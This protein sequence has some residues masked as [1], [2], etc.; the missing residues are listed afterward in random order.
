MRH[1]LAT[2]AVVAFAGAAQAQDAADLS[3]VPQ[4]GTMTVTYQE[5]VA[6]L[7]P[8]I[9]YDWQNWSMIKSLFDGLMGYEPGTTELRNELAE[10]HEV[11]E[12][13]MVHTFTLKDDIFFHN[14]REIMAEDVKY[15]LDR[16]T[17][18]E[19]Q[20]PGAGFF[21]MIEG[22]DAWNS[23]EGEGLSGVEVMDD[24][25]VQI[26]LSRPDATFGHV[27]ALNFASIVPA[28]GGGGVGPGLRPRPGRL[29]RIRTDGMDAGPAPRLRGV[30]PVPPR[31]GAE[32]RPGRLR[33]GAGPYR[34][35]SAGAA[36]AGGH[37]RRPDPAGAV[38]AG[39]ERPRAGRQC[40]RG[41]AVAH[42]L[43]D[44]ERQHGA[45]R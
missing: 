29:R 16:V 36:G 24:K 39:D 23:G 8:A 25:T 4:G 11:S 40:R 45:V 26:T 21:G 10:S 31:G 41:R 12:D 44:D 2:T 1:L 13:G 7:D 9:G 14:G 37:P 15:S 32:A 42:R 6:T 18:P 22:F 30:R 34:G 19:T 38:P 27:M 35:A 28:R 3:D 20:S 33:T 5:D 17:N 43:R